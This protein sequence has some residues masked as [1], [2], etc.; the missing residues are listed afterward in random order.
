MEIKVLGFA[1]AGDALGAPERVVTVPDGLR[2]ADLERQLVEEYPE[3]GPLWPRLAVAIG[4]QIVGAD[5]EIPAGAEVALLPPV[6]GGSGGP[7]R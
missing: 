3:L 5:D 4:G 2:V 7:G 6:S 1:S